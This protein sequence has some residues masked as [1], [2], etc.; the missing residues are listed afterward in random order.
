M[1]YD[2]M[3]GLNTGNVGYVANAIYEVTK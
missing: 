1:I 3:A 2:S